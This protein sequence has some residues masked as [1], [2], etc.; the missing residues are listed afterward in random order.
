MPRVSAMQLMG[1]RRAAGSLRRRH[2]R[3]RG[4][5]WGFLLSRSFE[6]SCRLGLFPHIA[7]S[8]HGE[9]HSVTVVVPTGANLRVEYAHISDR[10]VGEPRCQHGVKLAHAAVPGLACAGRAY[11]DEPDASAC[12]RVNDGFDVG[13]E[14]LDAEFRV[15]RAEHHQRGG[16]RW[17]AVDLLDR[18][19][20]A[21]VHAVARES[22]QPGDQGDRRAVTVSDH[23]G[24]RRA[25]VGR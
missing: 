13:V 9:M 10:R 18:L 7:V 5:A 11:P 16:L 2:G 19:G 17:Y 24:A 21:N 14:A 15:V 1:L 4:R 23:N 25:L 8:L 12:G 3:T 22:L 6:S 20:P